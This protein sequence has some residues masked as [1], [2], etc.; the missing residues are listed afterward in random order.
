[1]PL[2]VDKPTEDPANEEDPLKA[3][4]TAAKREKMMIA[5]VFML[6]MLEF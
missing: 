3:S 2:A 1:M 4:A 6:S 5:E